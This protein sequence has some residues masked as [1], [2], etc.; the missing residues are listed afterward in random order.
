[1]KGHLE[2]LLIVF[3]LSDELLNDDLDMQFSAMII[4]LKFENVFDDHCYS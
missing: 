1:M 2:T 4:L 3:F